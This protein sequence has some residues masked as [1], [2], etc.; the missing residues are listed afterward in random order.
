MLFKVEKFCRYKLVELPPILNVI[1][2]QMSSVGPRR[3][4]PTHTELI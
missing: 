3:W 4:L 2:G 1:L